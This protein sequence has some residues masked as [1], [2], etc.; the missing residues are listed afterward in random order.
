ML[1][2]FFPSLFLQSINDHIILDFIRCEEL[3]Y[4]NLPPKERKATWN[5]ILDES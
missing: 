5:Y 2:L 4:F 1:K 3:E